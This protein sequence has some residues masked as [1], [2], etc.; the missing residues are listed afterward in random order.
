MEKEQI[1][2]GFG[3]YTSSDVARI[4]RIPKAKA[5]YWFNGIVKKKL[6]DASNFQYYFESNKSVAVNFYMLLELYVFYK[7]RESKISPSEI[8]KTHT[9]LKSKTNNPYPFAFSKLLLFGKEILMDV[10]DQIL[11]ANESAQGVLNEIVIPLSEKISFSEKG[12]A[13]K[14]YPLGKNN[15]VVV[16]RNNQFGEPTIEGTN[17]KA[18]T[19]YNYYLGGESV[20]SIANLYNLSNSQVKEAISFCE[21]A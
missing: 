4:L 10:E 8:V 3:A 11:T 5:N 19:L 2:L 13:I 1:K 12:V 20:K 21:V 9:F 7:M 17:I 14:Y 16:S 18:A 15:S 6:Q